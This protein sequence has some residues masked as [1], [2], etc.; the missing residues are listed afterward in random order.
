LVFGLAFAMFTTMFALFAQQRLGLTAQLTGFVL[1]YV[2]IVAVLVQGVGV[3]WLSARYAERSII[4]AARVVMGAALL[5]W[6]FVPSVGAL[7]IVLTPLAASGGTLNT[8]INSALT[9]AVYAEEVGGVLGLSASLESL[10]RAVSP[11]LGG[12]LLESFGTWAPG[13]FSAIVMAWVISFAW[14]RLI[15]WPDGSLPPR[16]SEARGGRDTATVP[17]QEDGSRL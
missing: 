1:T 5:G 8:V 10:T 12:L 13:V 11:S 17:A 16:M 6:A 14:R 7:L 15:L 4:F 9:K 3:G 2:G